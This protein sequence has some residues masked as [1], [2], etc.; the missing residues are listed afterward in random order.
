MKLFILVIIIT[1]CIS[2]IV[3]NTVPNNKPLVGPYEV[4]H[5]T[6][7]VPGLYF[8]WDTVD[9]YYPVVNNN[10][11][12]SNVS[13]RFISFSH[14]AGGGLLLLPIVYKSLLTEI[15]S[16]GFVIAAHESSFMT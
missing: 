1:T 12:S 5:T 16:W 2:R 6:V 7:K 3:A 8:D 15:A 11:L 4:K 13:I 9:V 14:G 10:D